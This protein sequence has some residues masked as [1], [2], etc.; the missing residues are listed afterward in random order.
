MPSTPRYWVVIPAAGIGTRM[1]TA[2]PKQYLRLNGRTVLEH[3]LLRFCTH[4]AIAGIVVALAPEDPYWHELPIA[5]HE[6]IRT[7][8][9]GAERCHSVLHGLRVLREVADEEDWVLVH[10]A[11]RPCL[12]RADL[13][14][15][16]ETVS[17]HAVGG[18]LAAPA[19]DTMKRAGHGNEIRDTVDR[20]ELWHALTPQM[21]RLGLL[22][23][24]LAEAVEGGRLVTDEAQA[25]ELAGHHPLLVPGQADNIKITHPG[26]LEIAELFLARQEDGA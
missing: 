22:E 5:G 18:I 13:D 4:P 6:K 23:R 17:G 26:D 15:L 10:D 19:R 11:A 9:G 14:R 8:T 7:T 1:E 25:V 24:A 16:L 2:T 12:S 3:V 21:F 20:S